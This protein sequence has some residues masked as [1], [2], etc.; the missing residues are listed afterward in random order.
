MSKKTR[1]PI[2]HC[3][4]CGRSSHDRRTCPKRVRRNLDAF[5]GADGVIHPI[6]G[7]EY[8]SEGLLER[9]EERRQRDMTDSYQQQLED[10]WPAYG[11]VQR[12][13]REIVQL[14]I[15]R[16]DL[17]DDLAADPANKLMELRRGGK[18]A[19]E[20]DYV[21]WEQ[22]RKVLAKYGP[23]G[24][25][26]RPE[27]FRKAV[28]IRHGHKYLDFH[29]AFDVVAEDMGYRSTDALKDAVKAAWTKRQKLQAIEAKIVDRKREMEHVKPNPSRGRPKRRPHKP[30]VKA[31]SWRSV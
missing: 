6:R 18:D 8:Y 17:K 7:S 22:A 10:R 19:G 16:D 13:D 15:A 2:R 3:S 28:V 29:H 1:T 27:D 24:R 9:R 23:L 12:L 5:V 20:I 21:P 26:S 11:K 14:E 30:A 4:L 31:H 25:G